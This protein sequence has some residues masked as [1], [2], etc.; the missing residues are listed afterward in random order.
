MSNACKHCDKDEEAYCLEIG[1]VQRLSDYEGVKH[2]CYVCH[3]PTWCS[4]IGPKHKCRLCG[5]YVCWAHTS[6]PLGEP[7]NYCEN[8]WDKLPES[9]T[10]KI[11]AHLR[12]VEYWRP[13]PSER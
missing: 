7:Q 6:F 1:N 12:D 10:L 9:E 2:K 8:C 11:C 4:L 5:R 3:Q 13:W